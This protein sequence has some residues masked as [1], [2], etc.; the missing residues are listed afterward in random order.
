[1]ANPPPLPPIVSGPI[2]NTSPQ[3]YVHSLLPNS[4]VSVYNIPNPTPTTTPVGTAN[5]SAS[6]GGIWVPL[7]IKLSLGQQITAT[8]QYTGSDA[9]ILA[10]V[11][12]DP[13]PP[14]TRPVTVLDAPDP[15]PTP[16]FVSGLCTCMDWVYIDGLIP[17][18]TLKIELKNPGA[19]LPYPTVVNA[20]VTQSSQWFQLAA[21]AIAEGAVLEAQQSIG[22]R[23]STPLTQSNPIP[24][25]PVL[26][27]PVITPQPLDCQTNLGLSN[28]VPGA[29]LRIRD[30]VTEYFATNPSSSYNL[31]PLG[32][33]QVA[34]PSGEQWA[35]Q[36][37][38]R[39]N[40]ET[41]KPAPFTVT[42]Q[43][44]KTPKVGYK[45]CA[46]ASQLSVSDVVGGE[47]LSIAVSYSTMSG[48]APLKSLGSGGV[49]GPGPLPL[50]NG[51][52]PADAVG[53]VT[54]QIGALLCDTPSP[55]YASVTV[56]PPSKSIPAP[57]VQEP[58]YDCATFVF[59]QGANPGSLI[60]VFSGPPPSP[61]I[62]RSNPVVATTA[63][64]PV[65][66]WWRLAAGEHIFVKQQ[67]CNA[68]GQ[69]KS[70]P[71][72]APPPHLSAPTVAG[73]Y[74]LS[75]AT[76][77]LVDHV[78]PG[79]QVMLFVGGHA[80]GAPVDSIQAETGPPPALPAPQLIQVSLPVGW[81][82]LQKGEVLTA[83]QAFCGAPILPP[84]QGRGV[85][86]QAPES[87]PSGGLN[88]S[89]NYFMCVPIGPISSMQ[90]QNLTG[91][92]VTIEVSEDIVFG[93]IV[94]GS[95]PS[96]VLK[97]FGFQLN[98]YSQ[99]TFQQ[100]VISLQDTELLGIIN[101]YH[102]TGGLL[103]PPPPTQNLLPMALPSVAI[104][105]GYKMQIVLGYK[106]ENV[107]SVTWVVNGT[108]TV[109]NIPETDA[110]PIQTFT[111]DLVGP[112][113]AEHAVLKSGAGLFTYSASSRLTVVNAMPCVMAGGTGEQ[114]NSSYGKLSANPGNPF[115]Q[116]FTVRG[117]TTH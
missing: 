36:Y 5:T 46:D 87:D 44:P 61:P 15:L 90:C 30:G 16:V 107:N 104:P 35:Q 18:A 62:A 114:S 39:C 110:T 37:F 97:G 82:P 115:T 57:T 111:L 59:I 12:S 31:S 96:G 14:S 109:G 117:T 108:S 49:S 75:T 17:G 65:H 66:L 25:A 27:P 3:V 42:K 29:D 92:A 71:V 94:S 63:N 32:P 6:P 84:A 9:K 50:P 47:I 41:S 112:G 73:D 95:G 28:T 64:F 56:Q 85:M 79:A 76:S 51:W 106:G 8:Q 91:V 101:I 38:T 1:M 54:L 58:L 98:C 88:G 34:A 26:Q 78:A 80:R 2:F 72:V 53:P 93:D 43:A 89:S 60:Q 74:V 70:I 21:V 13:S 40:Q 23:K 33:L 105:K 48:K 7:T 4:K 99:T 45:P 100:Y 11:N 81:P 103:F 83:G 19:P 10:L 69:S 67:G 20:D 102:I 22:S 116:T 24:I 113:W 86:V 68:D 77:V 55:G 52:Y